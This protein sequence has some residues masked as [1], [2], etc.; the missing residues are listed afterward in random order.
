MIAHDKPPSR[1]SK[2]VQSNRGNLAYFASIHRLPR[3]S[4][5]LPLQPARARPVQG[6]VRSNLFQHWK[7]MSHPYPLMASASLILALSFAQVGCVGAK[8]APM[9]PASRIDTEHGYQQHGSTID[10]EDMGKTLRSE[11]VA[12]PYARRAPVLGTVG[13][14][15]AATG[16]ALIGWPLG[17][18]LRGA[19]HP[20]WGLA[21]AG[22]GAVA[23]SI[24]FVFWSVS[25]MQHAIE[26][27]NRA[28][29][30]GPSGR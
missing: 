28:L 17:E 13:T 14:L 24:P 6:R 26:A 19:E 25:D 18:K 11:P 20:S 12:G 21:Y 2:R 22:I 30:K 5:L 9:D 7:S 15:L 29:E 4:P 1:Y 8:L 3:G 27:H 10:P 23:V 16:G